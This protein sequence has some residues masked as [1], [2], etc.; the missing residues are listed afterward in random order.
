MNP[1]I[2]EFV[3][4]AITL[5]VGTALAF[6]VNAGLLTKPDLEQIV[7]AAVLLVVAIAT[8]AWRRWLWPFLRAR[9]GNM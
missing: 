5:I 4:K 9:F 2:G 3:R 1:I 8:F 7:S 6:L